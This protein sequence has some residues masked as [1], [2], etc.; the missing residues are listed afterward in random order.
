MKS[1]QSAMDSPRVVPLNTLREIVRQSGKTRD[2]V[3]Y[4]LRTRDVTPVA[5]AGNQFVYS[6]DQVAFVLAELAAI[7][8][9]R[10]GDAL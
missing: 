6:E 3:L 9:E 10:H 8:A 5:K 1:E 4:V 7:A 2:Q